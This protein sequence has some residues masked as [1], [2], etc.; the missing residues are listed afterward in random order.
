ML[1]VRILHLALFLLI[2]MSVLGEEAPIEECP[3]CMRTT[4]IG[5]TLV[6]TL[7][8]HT[9]YERTGTPLGLVCATKQTIQFLTQGIASF[10]HTITLSF[11]LGPGLRF[12]LGQG[13]EVS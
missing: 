1:G 5:N 12:T 11:Y 7:L 2:P 13:K 6:M 9:Y 3:H 10:M 4:W 8:Y